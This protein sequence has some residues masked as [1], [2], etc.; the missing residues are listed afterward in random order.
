MSLSWENIRWQRIIE[1]QQ[2]K[3]QIFYRKYH[4]LCTIGIDD[5]TREIS[6][7][8][9]TGVRKGPNYHKGHSRIL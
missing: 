7:D 9:M 8:T 6:K 1:E 4:K 5:G 3:A 2:A